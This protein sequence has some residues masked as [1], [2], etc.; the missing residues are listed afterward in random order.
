MI[1]FLSELMR[2]TIWYLPTRLYNISEK[3]ALENHHIEA[4]ITV[5]LTIFVG[6]ISLILT[7][8]FGL[9]IINTVLF[10]AKYLLIGLIKIL[11]KLFRLEKKNESN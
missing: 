9:F 7:F 10:S 1:Q 4:F 2:E 8:I 11:S 6:M 5:T 3:A